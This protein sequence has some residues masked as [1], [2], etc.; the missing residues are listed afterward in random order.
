MLDGEL[1]T[2]IENTGR[3]S[4]EPD[5]MPTLETES[6]SESESESN[7]GPEESS[8]D[9]SSPSEEWPPEQESSEESSELQT[10]DEST[11]LNETHLLAFVAPSLTTD[12]ERSPSTNLLDDTI[13]HLHD[14]MKDVGKEDAR[15]RTSHEMVNATCNIAK[16]MRDLMK[17]KLDIWEM[18]RD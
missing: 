3:R 7:T 9:E 5:E 12:K 13:V 4:A 18:A 14:L 17:L 11:S 1:S 8:G 6:A 2:R 15:K 10:S 16:N